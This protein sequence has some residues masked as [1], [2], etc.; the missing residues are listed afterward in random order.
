MLLP[1]FAEGFRRNAQSMEAMAGM[2]DRMGKSDY[3][4]IFQNAQ[5]AFSPEAFSVGNDMLGQLF[6]TKEF[7]RNLAQQT[8]AFTGIQNNIIKQMLPVVASILTGGMM[9]QQSANPLN[10]MMEQM[11]SAM[12]GSSN[13]LASMMEGFMKGMP[14]MSSS[15]KEDGASWGEELG[16]LAGE[17]FKSGQQV[18]DAQMKAIGDI[19]EQFAGSKKDG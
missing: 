5:N 11:Q 1:A 18:Q 6:G 3:G 9:K 7:S 15:D 10:A 4:D 13:P 8:E 17:M 12:G 2:V 19:F 14:G 16:N